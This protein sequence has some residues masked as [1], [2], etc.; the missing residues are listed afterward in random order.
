[1]NYRS[2]FFCK[3]TNHGLILCRVKY[4]NV[5]AWGSREAIFRFKVVCIAIVKW[6]THSLGSR[7][8]FTWAVELIWLVR[9]IN[10]LIAVIL[11]RNAGAIA[12]SKQVR[13]TPTYWRGTSWG[14]CSLKKS[15]SKTHQI[16]QNR[17]LKTFYRCNH[18][19]CK[20]PCPARSCVCDFSSCN[21]IH[22][23]SV[24]CIRFQ[25]YKLYK[26]KINCK[27]YTCKA[28]FIFCDFE[29]I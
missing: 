29:R 25:V 22:L 20:G 3:I 8:I 15:G 28:G 5:Y 13:P 14:S 1:M 19:W 23:G 17:N 4:H 7:L 24:E 27:P 10:Y 6:V 18:P 16:S 11:D 9:T 12:A 26:D 2:F 21:T